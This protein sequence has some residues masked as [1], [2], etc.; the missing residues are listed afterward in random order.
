[1]SVT[2]VLLTTVMPPVHLLPEEK[3][4]PARKPKYVYSDHKASDSALRFLLDGDPKGFDQLI[5]LCVIAC[6]GLYFPNAWEPYTQDGS[7]MVGQEEVVRDFIVGWLG[8]ELEKYK[9]DF[10]E[11][12]QLAERRLRHI[13]RRCRLAIVAEIRTCPACGQRKTKECLDCEYIFS[14]RDINTGAKVCPKCQST[15]LHV[16]CRHKC[17]TPSCRTSIDALFSDGESAGKNKLSDYVVEGRGTFYLSERLELDRPMLEKIHPKLHTYLKIAF[18]HFK[19][20]G[21]KRYLTTALAAHEGVS[22]KV[23]RKIKKEVL[24]AIR[25]NLHRPVLQE[26]YRDLEH[27]QDPN[28]PSLAIPMSK[29][30]KEAVEARREASR[31]MRESRKELGLK[32]S[33]APNPPPEPTWADY[34]PP[35]ANR[36]AECSSATTFLSAD[37]GLREIAAQDVLEEMVK[38]VGDEDDVRAY[39]GL[40]EGDPIPLNVDT[41]TMRGDSI[42]YDENTGYD[43]ENDD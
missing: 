31:L 39:F 6:R 15:E 37:G 9:S 18:L 2:P 7:K 32:P 40:E 42:S 1:M 26:L 38:D 4:Q 21:Y 12:V 34:D 43:V 23:A 3:P 27:S 33:P 5:G 16:V 14:H 25:A 29:R 11:D 35:T 8:K 28:V 19:R 17:Q 30:T 10:A 36:D 24:A 20:S 41:E 13:P 22:L